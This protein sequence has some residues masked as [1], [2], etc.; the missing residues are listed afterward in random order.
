MGS[1]EHHS[2]PACLHPHL[3]DAFHKQGYNFSRCPECGFV[4]TNPYPSSDVISAYYNDISYRDSSQDVYPKAA[5]RIRRG[6]LKCLR[7]LP[8]IWRKDALDLGCGGGMMPRVFHFW[9]AR[10]SSGVDISQ[11]SIDYARAHY[12]QCT[13]YC[14]DTTNFRRRGLTYDFIFSSEVIEHF[15]GPDE[16]MTTITAITRP[17]GHVYITTPDIGHPTVPADTASW[18][19]V[20]PPEHIQLFTRTALERLFERYG[21]RLKRA[22]PK[23]SAAHS[24]LFV[25]NI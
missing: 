1:T 3:H 23:R 4:F 16:F 14:D 18:D 11:T 12:P 21:F 2:C 20:R 8:Y 22:W 7:F 19:V 24:L 17:G 13:F 9:G 10:T 5:S 25:R 15:P 6:L